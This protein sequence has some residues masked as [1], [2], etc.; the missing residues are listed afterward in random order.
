MLAYLQHYVTLGIDLQM[1]NIVL[2]SI[3]VTLSHVITSTLDPFLSL[4]FMKADPLWHLQEY[5]HVLAMHLCYTHIATEFRFT[6]RLFKT[7]VRCTAPSLCLRNRFEMQ[8]LNLPLTIVSLLTSVY[9]GLEGS[10]KSEVATLQTINEVKTIWPR[11]CFVVR[12][13]MGS[14]SIKYLTR[15]VNSWR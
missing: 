5:S 11:S 7:I 3:T 8:E 13:R 2:H 12:L 9:R 1:E 14:I 10:A 6:A 15:R 4:P